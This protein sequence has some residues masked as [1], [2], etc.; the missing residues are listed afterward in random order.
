LNSFQIITVSVTKPKCRSKLKEQDN[1][2]LHQAI[3]KKGVVEVRT[4]LKRAR[5]YSFNDNRREKV[6]SISSNNKKASSPGQYQLTTLI[7]A[8]IE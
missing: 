1:Q 6:E 8:M 2:D 4:I 5:E 3:E 7:C